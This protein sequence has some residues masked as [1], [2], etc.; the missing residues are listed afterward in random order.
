M[1][2]D[3]RRIASELP[4]KVLESSESS[5]IDE[6]GEEAEREQSKPEPA[7]HQRVAILPE[8]FPHEP[9]PSAAFVQKE[10]DGD[11]R[12]IPGVLLPR[13]RR[14]A[15]LGAPIGVTAPALPSGR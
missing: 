1:S 3:F 14:S 12:I 7:K 9:H 8:Q 5:E 6:I 11:A 15:A 13:L 4:L 2:I 10:Y